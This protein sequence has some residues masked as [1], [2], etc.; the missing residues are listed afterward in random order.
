MPSRRGVSLARYHEHL[1]NRPTQGTA[2]LPASGCLGRSPSTL[3]L[4]NEW[5]LCRHDHARWFSDWRCIH[6]DTA[7]ADAYDHACG[8]HDSDGV[9]DGSACGHRHVS[10]AGASTMATGRCGWLPVPL[11]TSRASLGT[12]PQCAL[13]WYGST[14]LGARSASARAVP[15][16]GPRDD[17]TRHVRPRHGR[18]DANGASRRLRV[19]C[20]RKL[21]NWPGWGPTSDPIRR[22]ASAVVPS[23][24]QILRTALLL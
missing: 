2:N 17:A 9:S 11:V 24:Q 3:R 4:S 12:G 1:A 13:A 16:H 22:N 19:N 8:V 18:S 21:A 15:G 23:S 14:S 7:A 20:S 10:S 5:W 6:E